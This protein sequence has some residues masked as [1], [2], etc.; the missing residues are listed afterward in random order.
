[1]SEY[2]FDRIFA[3]TD[4]VR[5]I[6]KEYGTPFYLYDQKGIEASVQNLH[7]SFTWSEGY[8]NYFVV[9]Q[10][11]NPSILKILHKTG[12]GVNAGSL[13]ELQLA[14]ACGFSGAQLIYEP[15]QR[16]LNAEKFAKE[17][18]A[19]WMINSAD[20]LPDELPQRIILHYHPMEERLP[21]VQFHR[22]GKSKNGIQRPRIFDVISDLHNRGATHIGVA[23]QVASYS[24]QPGF[25]ARKAEMLLDL[26]EET[27]R[28]LGLDLWCLHL[29]EGPGLPY[30]PRITAPSVVEEAEKI[31]NLLESRTMNPRIFTG[32]NRRLMEHCGLLVTKILECRDIYYSFLVLDAGF[33]QYIRPALK[34]AYR[35]IS[36][37]GKNQTENRKKY[38]LVGQ[39]PD[40]TDRPAQKGRML[41]RVSAGEYCIIHDVGCGG[42]SMPLLYGFS[43]IAAEYLYDDNGDIRQIAPGRTEEEVMNFLTAL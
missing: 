16:D 38:Y 35:H 18:D 9:R 6:A 8:Q 21:T 27:K 42:R 17:L 14:K 36:V 31:R 43:P 20:L 39:M 41:P 7:Q 32:V 24:I 26:A 12:T 29:G 34:S 37:L 19:T 3:P 23:L 33:C 15:T 10:N 25:W 30:Q 1:M 40:E 22:I 4:T 2:S 13:C 11:P 5:S 28:R